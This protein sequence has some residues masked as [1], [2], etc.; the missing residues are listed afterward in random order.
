MKVGYGGDVPPP[1]KPLEQLIENLQGFVW[2]ATGNCKNAV[3]GLTP[4]ERA[5]IYLYTMECMYYQLNKTLRNEE[6]K[7]LVPY[8]SYLKLFLTALWKLSD[9][10]CLVIKKVEYFRKKNE[11][12]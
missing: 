6:R 2:T 9:V 11:K 5:A 4:D 10:K 3:E 8:F 12:K 7:Q 1:L